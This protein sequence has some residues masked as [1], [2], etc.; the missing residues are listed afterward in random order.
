MKAGILAYAISKPLMAPPSRATSTQI[1]IP[2]YI[3]IP[4]LFVH[5]AMT[6]IDNDIIVPTDRSIPPETITRVM[7][8]DS[9]ALTEPCNPTVSR[10][11]GRIKEGFMIAMTATTTKSKIT[12]PRLSKSFHI[13]ADLGV[14]PNLY[15]GTAGA[16]RG[17]TVGFIG[18]SYL[19]LW[20]G[21]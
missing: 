9:T 7:P 10:L 1:S 11:A 8:I 3:G 18:I 4:R 21:R 16:G 12:G 5:I 15:W 13:C 14:P 17:L 6:T 20:L 2:P 19:V